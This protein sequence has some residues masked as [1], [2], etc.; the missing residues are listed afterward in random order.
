MGLC[1]MGRG[2]KSPSGKF[3]GRAA[4][5]LLYTPTM[6]KRPPKNAKRG[7]ERGEVVRRRAEDRK[8]LPA[9]L[10][11][12]ASGDDD[13]LWRRPAKRRLNDPR[14]VVLVPGVANR[15]ARAV[16]EARERRLRAALEA[17][18]DEALALELME[19]A[20]LRLWRA[21]NI[22]GWDVFVEHVLGISLE[23]A[24]ELLARGAARWGSADPAPEEV[25]AGWMRAEAG[26][27]EASPAGVARLQGAPGEERLVLEV[28]MADAPV[29]LAAVGRRAAPLAREQAQ[30]QKDVVD[31]PK[32]L[33]RLSR[34]ERDPDE[35]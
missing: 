9:D 11:A 33:P 18:D 3:P 30:P 12:F 28:S 27:L 13:A 32:G 26:L 4:R 5:S 1:P 31:R 29:A 19:A 22:V 14:P 10:E 6:N 35:R 15:D 20:R 24:S 7:P 8:R 16:Y 25:V 23:R 21:H 17:G 34:L 2:S